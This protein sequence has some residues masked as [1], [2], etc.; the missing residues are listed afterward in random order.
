MNLFGRKIV[1]NVYLQD[2]SPYKLKEK[3]MSFSSDAGFRIVF[4]VQ[5]NITSDPNKAVVQLYNLSPQTIDAFSKSGLW[6]DL[7][8]GFNTPTLIYSGKISTVSVNKNKADKICTIACQTEWDLDKKIYT[9]SFAGFVTLESILFDVLKKSEIPYRKENILIS[10]KSGERGYCGINTVN[11]ILN[12]LADWYNFSW[13]LQDYGF[14]AISDNMV[15]PNVTN[16]NSPIIDCYKIPKEDD[17]TVGG[18]DVT[19]LLDGGFQ[20]GNNVT[21]NSKYNGQQTFKIFKLVHS[22]DSH[23]ATWTTNLNG[24]VAGSLKQK[25]VNKNIFEFDQ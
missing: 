8:A 24:Y 14:L 17:R 15:M 20:I 4:D 7:Y 25:K 13:S 19:C 5:K 3:I 21:F 6:I 10:D 23:S 18:F 12:Q 9:G 2:N 16:I 1:L 22:G 11:N